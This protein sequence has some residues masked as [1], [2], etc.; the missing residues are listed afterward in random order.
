LLKKF[1]GMEQECL[2]R[3]VARYVPNQGGDDAGDNQAGAGDGEGDYSLSQKEDE[4][5]DREGTG[6]GVT[7]DDGDGGKEEQEEKRG[8]EQEEGYE[9]DV[10]SIQRP[11][12]TEMI[13]GTLPSAAVT[14]AKPAAPRTELSAVRLPIQRLLSPTPPPVKIGDAGF[15]TQISTLVNYVYGP[16]PRHE[17]DSRLVTIFHSYKGRE[18]VLLKLLETKAELKRAKMIEE[19]GVP[20]NVSYLSEVDSDEDDEDDGAVGGIDV[21]A[22]PRPRKGITMSSTGDDDTI[23]TISFGTA[24]FQKVVEMNNRSMNRSLKET[25]VHGS[26]RSFREEKTVVDGE[27]DES[28][29]KN[30]AVRSFVKRKWW[31]REGKS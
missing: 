19:R 13:L 7:D 18:G 22:P 6:G 15:A 29:E 14:A 16:A 3:L 24:S 30:K 12:A 31:K 28:G 2:D 21:M 11:A 20:L 4:E 5:R 17:H 25:L 10:C 9:E 23:S 8:E 1:E 26:D 27:E